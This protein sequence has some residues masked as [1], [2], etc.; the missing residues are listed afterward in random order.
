MSGAKRI[1]RDADEVEHDRRHIEHVVSPVAPAG[2]E[3]VEIAEDFFRPEVDAAFAG[4]AVREFD[5]GDALRPEEKKKG[6][7]PEPDGDAAVGG[8]GRDD[9]EVEDGDYE[10]EDEIAAPEGA[11][12]VGLG[13]GLGGGGQSLSK[14]RLLRGERDVAS[15][16]ST[17]CFYA[18]A[19][20]GARPTRANL[21][22]GQCRLADAFLLGF[23]ERCGDIV[24]S[25]QMLVDVSLG[26]LNRNRPLLVPPVG[27]R[28]Y[29]AVDHGEP[30]M[31]PEIDIDRGPIA[32]VAN[33]FGIKHQRAVGSGLRDVSLQ[34]DFRDGLAISLGELL[35]ELLDVSIVIAG[36]NFAECREA[37]SHRNR[38][39]VVSATMENFV[40]RD[41]VHDGP[42]GAER[43]EGEA[44]AD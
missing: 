22:R 31:T 36:E 43:G 40:L 38:V 21:M 35:T 6:D 37:R 7:D 34:A 44:S 28:H 19:G 3:S 12:E 2:E 10:E 26:V 23:G 24:E 39:G 11:D 33:F 4:I 14:T 20:E 32:V 8:D 5:D 18:G 17:E 15:Y 41:E 13:V 9:I 25:G 29:T 1:N 30:V 42:A 16:V 27:L